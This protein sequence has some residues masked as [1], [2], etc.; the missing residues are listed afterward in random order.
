MY[1]SD[2]DRIAIEHWS[3]CIA[4]TGRALVNLNV[5]NDTATFMYTQMSYVDQYRHRALIVDMI[6][7]SRLLEDALKEAKSRKPS[8]H[9]KLNS[10]R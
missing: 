2:E 1:L 8:L 10:I 4:E 5:E 6:A 3:N 9:E 7:Y